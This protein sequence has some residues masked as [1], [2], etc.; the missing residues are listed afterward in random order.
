VLGEFR[1]YRLIQ[2]RLIA[3]QGLELA[4]RPEAFLNVLVL[5]VVQ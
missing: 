4:N 1:Y 2:A 3:A 5:K